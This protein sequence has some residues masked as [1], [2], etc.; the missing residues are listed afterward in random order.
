MTPTKLA[1]PILAYILLGAVA[2]IAIF[3]FVLMHSPEVGGRC[4]AETVNGS[5][6]P[7]N[8]VASV[9]FHLDALRFFATATFGQ[10]VLLLA[11]L[12]VA[13]LAVADLETNRPLTL[14]FTFPRVNGSPPTSSKVSFCQW[15]ALHECS[16]PQIMTMFG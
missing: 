12:L 16:P 11:I 2:G 7:E 14:S 13:L 8:P 6:C 4:A 10:S 1:K 3:G 9:I 15:L 5:V